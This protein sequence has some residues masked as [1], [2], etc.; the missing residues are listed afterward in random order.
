M[1][2]KDKTTDDLDSREED[3]YLGREI[4]N[5]IVE[6]IVSASVKQCSHDQQE[7]VNEIGTSTGGRQ[8]DSHPTSMCT[9]SGRV[10]GDRCGRPGGSSGAVTVSR[11]RKELVGRRD[12]KPKR[13]KV[14]LLMIL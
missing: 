4:A 6:D 8:P 11:K 10:G 2:T 1:G 12:K 14:S 5:A 9:D 13:K 3:K 7:S